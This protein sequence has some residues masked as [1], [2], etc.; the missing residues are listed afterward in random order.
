M[1]NNQANQIKK[2]ATEFFQ[3]AREYLE[4][5]LEQNDILNMSSEITL[6]GPIFGMDDNSKDKHKKLVDQCICILGVDIGSDEEIEGLAWKHVWESYSDLN[7]ILEISEITDRF[8]DDIIQY[9]QRSH[10]YLAPNYLFEFSEHVQKIEIGPVQAIKTEYLIADQKG[11]A[12]DKT[13]WQRMLAGENIPMEIQADKKFDWS[14]SDNRFLLKLPKFSWYFPINSIKVA[15]RNAEEK[16]IWLINVAISLLRLC[17][18]NPTQSKYPKVGDLEEMPLT[19]PKEFW[20]GTRHEEMGL[21]LHEI[22][23][24]AKK[25]IFHVGL[26]IDVSSSVNRIGCTYAVD[27]S[28]VKM[29]EEQEF[30]DR[31]QN[32]FYP[33]KNSLAERFGQ[34]LG[35]LT[36]G[37][38]T[39]DRAERLLFFFTAIEALLSSDDKNAP[40]VQTISRYAATILHTDPN[41]RMEFAKRLRSLYERRS[42]LVHAG[43][44]NVSQSQSM[45]TQKIAE[46]IYKVVM[47]KYC[48][49]SKFSEFQKSLSMASYGSPW[50]PPA[51]NT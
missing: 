23:K 11:V 31:A 9:E 48:L 1:D 5:Q 14:I 42:G 4:N 37:R 18:P 20:L 2:L 8:F 19:E 17:Y 7:S 12:Q 49:N 34:G 21:V 3:A 38:Q 29:T 10:G 33:A 47:E 16:A 44:R 35:W 39:G 15:R 22:T 24:P 26:S 36:R 51:I 41:K 45:E 28:V 50:P 40:V 32:I 27:D 13:I 25:P 6:E 43:K 30:R 46:E